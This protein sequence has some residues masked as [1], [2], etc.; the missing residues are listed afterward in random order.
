[1]FNYLGILKKRQ[2]L[3]YTFLAVSALIKINPDLNV[4]KYES[5]ILNFG[6]YSLIQTFF[7]LCIFEYIIL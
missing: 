6:H 2:V 5:S 4:D 3:K 1:M 7:K